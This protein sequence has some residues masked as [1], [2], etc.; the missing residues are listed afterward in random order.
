MYNWLC[1][2]EAGFMQILGFTCSQLPHK[3]WGNYKHAFLT[4]DVNYLLIKT[5]VNNTNIFIESG[6]KKIIGGS[7]PR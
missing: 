2:C 4:G 5:N 1:C 7:L 6:Y 3:L